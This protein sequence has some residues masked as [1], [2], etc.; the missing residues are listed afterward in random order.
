MI[1]DKMALH[2]GER[3][4]KEIYN[5]WFLFSSM[6]GRK[7]WVFPFSPFFVLNVIITG[8]ENIKYT[9]SVFWLSTFKRALQVHT[10]LAADL[11]M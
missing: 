8:L 10:R 3:K 11:Y 1:C 6:H 9:I 5:A 4:T 7:Y 2:Q